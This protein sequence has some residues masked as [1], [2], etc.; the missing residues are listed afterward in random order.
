MS[1]PMVL[2][3]KNRGAILDPHNLRPVLKSQWWKT[4]QIP[5]V[6]GKLQNITVSY[7]SKT[8]IL[9]LPT[10]ERTKSFLFVSGWRRDIQQYYFTIIFNTCLMKLHMAIPL[11]FYIFSKGRD[12]INEE[13]VKSEK[14]WRSHAQHYRFFYN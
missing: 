4:Q 1:T 8:S 2:Q 12:E 13:E 14:L 5:G 3:E 10:R 11:G 7:C 6:S 9:S